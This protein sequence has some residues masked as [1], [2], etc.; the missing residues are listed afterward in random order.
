MRILDEH[1]LKDCPRNFPTELLNEEWAITNHGQTLAKLDS[2]GG[3]AVYE[4]ILNI[5]RLPHP[6]LGDKR[7]G[8]S[9][10]QVELLKQ[11][12]KVINP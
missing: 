3:L 12:I 1:E 2:R 5:F 7:F 10:E 6:S 11:I 4:I 9:Q 8:N